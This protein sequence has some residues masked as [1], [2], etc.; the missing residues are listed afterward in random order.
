[1]TF[2]Y[3]FALFTTAACANLIGLIIS[4]AFNSAVTIY[5]IIPLVMIPM[6]VLSGAMFN[7]EKLNRNITSVNKVPLVAE[8]MP[9][10]WAY[11]AL[12]VRQFKDN[13][14]NA[15][16]FE[17]ERKISAANFKSA[18][19][20]PELQDRLDVLFDTYEEGGDLA[21]HVNML[22]VLKNEV[23][24]EQDSIDGYEFTGED[25]SVEAFDGKFSST[26]DDFLNELN[27]FYLS[28]YTLV[29]R[30]KQKYLDELMEE[31]R[32]VYFRLLNK[33]HNESVADHVKKIYEKN[34]IVESEGRL[35][36]QIDPIYLYPESTRSQFYAPVK[37]LGGKYFDTYWFNMAFIWFLTILLYGVLYFDLLHKLIDAPVF[38]KKIRYRL[39]A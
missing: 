18:Y 34:P 19:L 12:M 1:M 11:E 10:K 29:N 2:Q 37:L 27:D 3:W 23:L 16:F 21:K 30:K 6:M 4:S 9:T 39:R 35:Y 20:I 25:F 38:K 36:Q 32:D 31:K 17:M 15:N 28:R 24:R 7:F 13:R 5:I 26:V 14:F 22:E 8:V 33:Y